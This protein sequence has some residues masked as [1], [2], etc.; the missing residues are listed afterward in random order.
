M[1]LIYL[2][3]IS[4]E[5]TEPAA[6][7]SMKFFILLSA[8]DM[9]YYISVQLELALVDLSPLGGKWLQD[10][11][12][13]KIIWFQPLLISESIVQAHIFHRKVHVQYVIFHKACWAMENSES[14]MNWSALHKIYR[15]IHYYGHTQISQI[16]TCSIYGCSSYQ[17][18]NRVI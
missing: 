13:Q 18:R 12:D 17:N 2:I 10:T 1:Q 8:N 7:T 4:V 16:Y 15:K 9:M 5:V 6:Y 3:Y 14:Y 11:I